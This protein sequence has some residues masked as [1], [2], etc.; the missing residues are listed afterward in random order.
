MAT[1]TKPA[2]AAC[3]LGPGFV[4]VQGPPVEVGSIE[5]RNSGLGIARFR[6]FDEREATRL[7]CVTIRNDID[8][9]Y[10]AIRRESRLE[11]F[12]AGLITEISDKNV[13]HSV[14]DPLY[15]IY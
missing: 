2:T 8:A 13:G 11:I 15:L 3:W 6:H 7:T 4:H 12:L 14:F 5:L 9:F 1:S 10:A